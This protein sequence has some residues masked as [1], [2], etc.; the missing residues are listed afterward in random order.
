MLG[1]ASLQQKRCL[2]HEFASPFHLHSLQLSPQEPH[3]DL[4]DHPG[5]NSG[6]EQFE[7][8]DDDV[9]ALSTFHRTELAFAMSFP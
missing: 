6:L 8:D 7:V 9:H 2:G 3:T 5:D 1:M 4:C